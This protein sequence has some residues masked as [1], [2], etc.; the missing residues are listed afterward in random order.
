MKKSLVVMALT[1]GSIA[2]VLASTP[3]LNYETQNLEV[4]QD[5]SE[6]GIEQLPAP[7]TE[8]LA[9][10]HPGATIAKAYVNGESQY[11]LE[12]TKEDGSIAE[13]FADAEGNWLEM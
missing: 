2:T 7:I 11:K 4:F 8:A 9:K 3:N 6:I 5:F 12:I 13:L 10:D 1:L